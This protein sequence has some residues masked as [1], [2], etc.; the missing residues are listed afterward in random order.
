MNSD[1][2]FIELWNDYLEGELDESGIAELQAIVAGDDRLLRMAADSYQIHRLLGLIAQD[3]ASRQEDF[4]SATLARLPADDAHFV[5]GV[6][7]HLPQGS[8]RKGTT[9][10]MLL[11]KWRM[12]IAAAAVVAL[13]A[14]VVF[15]RPKS[16]LAIVRI[17]ELNGAVQWTGDGG[18]VVPDLYVG[19]ALRGGTLESLSADSW[20][21]LKF[22]DGSTVTVSGQSVL[23]ISAHQQKE[24]HLR[25]GSLSASVMPQPDGKLMLIHTPTARLEVLG[26]QLNVEAEP[27]STMLSVNKGR[28]RVTRLVDGS[29][30]EV[31]AEHQVV[32]SVDRNAELKVT[33]R[34]RPVTAWQS[35]LPTDGLYGKWLPELGDSNGSLGTAPMLW[36]CHEKPITLYLVALSVSRSR[37]TPVLLTS[38]GKFRI[39]GQIESAGN[40]YFGLTTRQ[41]KGGFAGKF[42]VERHFNVVEETG[43]FVDIELRLEDFRPQ[44]KELT[45]KFPDKFP[46]SPI[47]LELV[48]WWC[49]TVNED[50]GLRITHV[51]LDADIIEPEAGPD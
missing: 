50:A 13:I 18:Q 6:M 25:V 2:R 47:G 35:D 41:V 1:E 40:V 29:V 8:P 28:V 45:E 4:V 10:R 42:L 21:D 37:P 7:Q 49:C 26:T 19:R 48:D 31:P 14:G 16:E 32:A 12:A 46:D 38:G 30:T 22:R 51:E 36:G 39:R 24:L 34:P 27:S 9:V 44:E 3:S 43:Q 15:L 17:T 23:T 33:R 11:A 20:A 5:D